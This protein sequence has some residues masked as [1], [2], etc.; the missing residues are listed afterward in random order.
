M[1]CIHGD[2]VGPCD[3]IVT[4][5]EGPP[6]RCGKVKKMSRNSS[7]ETKAVFGQLTLGGSMALD[8]L[9]NGM[10]VFMA[11]IMIGDA[12]AFEQ[13]WEIPEWASGFVA[14]IKPAEAHLNPVLVTQM[15]VI[16]WL[17]TKCAEWEGIIGTAT[18]EKMNGIQVAILELDSIPEV[19]FERTGK[20]KFVPYN[21]T[22]KKVHKTKK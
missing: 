15:S 6:A 5:E 11:S 1:V 20:G 8:W 18:M 14:I 7:K 2:T 12:K 17:E 19:V 3:S 4:M 21:P 16:R 22:E 9:K 13:R 10:V